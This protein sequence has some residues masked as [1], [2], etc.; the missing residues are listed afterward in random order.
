MSTRITPFSQIIYEVTG[1]SDPYMS[2]EEAASVMMVSPSTIYDYRTDRTE[3]SY[4]K[5]IAL[6]HEL[7]KKGY[8]KLSLQFWCNGRGRANGDTRDE[9]CSIVRSLGMIQENPGNPK[10]II[11]EAGSIEKDAR[12][13]RAEGEAML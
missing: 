7:N 2:V 4:S 13:L 10:V 5:I 9:T 11:N 8:H 1:G 6:A 12:N 3:P